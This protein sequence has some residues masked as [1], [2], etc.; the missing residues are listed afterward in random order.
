M[1]YKISNITERQKALFIVSLIII[2]LSVFSIYLGMSAHSQSIDNVMEAEEREVDMTIDAHQDFLF[3]HYSQRVSNLLTTH[4]DIMEALVQGDA[5]LFAELVEPRFK[6]LQRENPNLGQL[7]FYLP[8]GEI[9]I[10]LNDSKRISTDNERSRPIIDAVRNTK[11]MQAG[12]ELGKNGPNYYLGQPV[13]FENKEIGIMEVGISPFEVV[14]ALRKKIGS[15]V[16]IYFREDGKGMKD[17]QTCQ[18]FMFENYRIICNK[19][20]IFDRLPPG[21]RFTKDGQEVVIADQ[22]YIVHLHEVFHDFQKKPVGGII[23]LQDISLLLEQKNFFIMRMFCFS[24]MLVFS[25]LVVLHFSFG[26]LIK[27]LESS[28]KRYKDLAVN[29]TREIES[30]SQSKKEIL[31]VKNVWEKTFNAVSDI[32]TIQDANMKI[33]RVNKAACDIFQASPEELEGKY[34]Y[35]VFRG[36]SEPCDGC[37]VMQ[38]LKD[39]KSYSAQIEHPNLQKTFWVSATPIKDDKGRTTAVAHFARD[40]T[41]FKQLENQ[42]LQASKMEAVG[43]LAGGVAH[44]FN[45]MLS[46]IIGYSELGLKQLSASDPLRSNF[47]TIY[48]AGKRAAHL[49]RQL[50]AFSRKQ[51]L[52][53]EPVDLNRTVKDMAKLLDRLIGDDV[54]IRISFQDH[55]DVIKADV[56][57]IEQ[58]LMNLAINARDAMPAGGVLTMGTDSYEA[59][60]ENDSP[61]KGVGPG[62]YVTLRVSDSG[63]GMTREV[64]EKIFEPFFTTKELGKGTGLGLSTIYGIVRQHNAH[65]HVF[66]EPNKGTTFTLFF[67]AANM[68]LL[69]NTLK[70]S[71]PVKG[72]S[73][74]ILVVDNEP[75]ILNLIVDLLNPLGYQVVTAASGDEA[76]EVSEK[77][78][79]KIDLL[80]TDVVM[81]GINGPKLAELLQGS[82]DDL[83]VIFMSGHTE[84]IF[85]MRKNMDSVSFFCQKPIKRQS[86]AQTVRACLEQQKRALA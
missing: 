51:S 12:Y 57:Q 67:P 72:G 33:H 17:L 79:G 75:I 55:I 39:F 1:I 69:D 41:E 5:K 11:K 56:G 52:N 34:C 70:S 53:V 30:H 35:E 80:I 71:P 25:S 50:L 7:A 73:E 63:E 76:L 78:N 84:T 19:Q 29:L 48:E 10:V 2:V 62:K 81:P 8:N 59:L 68:P 6:A 58:I 38:S 43:R 86:L 16:W 18:P 61:Y 15:N 44:D 66:S 26:S 20:S 4:S 49:T 85:S 9:F 36:E 32:I 37:S 40:L 64:Q 45:N 27:K 83:K 82:V 54:E 23:A 47:S 13:F 3:T 65:I 31:K 46:P 22:T 77:L 24:L 28:K 60:K 21:T 14:E 42:L 74:T